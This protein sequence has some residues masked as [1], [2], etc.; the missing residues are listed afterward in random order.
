MG[1]RPQNLRPGLEAEQLIALPR[2]HPVINLV[3]ERY[4]G[5]KNHV[6]MAHILCLAHQHV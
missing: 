1:E 2:N 5:S 3:L 6:E 4:Y